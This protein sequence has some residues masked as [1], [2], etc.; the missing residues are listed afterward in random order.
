MYLTDEEICMLEQL[1][2]LDEDVAAAAGI[3]NFFGKINENMNNY[4]V[5][6]ILERFNDAALLRLATHTE[7]ICDA[8]MSGFEWAQVISYLKNSRLAQLRL[9]GIYTT[10]GDNYYRAAVWDEESQKY[11]G[12]A[13]YCEKPE[14]QGKSLEQILA[15]VQDVIK[16]PLGLCFVDDA[17]PNSAI[18]AYKGT[19]GQDE[20]ADNVEATTEYA[21]E[22]QQS[23]LAF[24]NQMASA[25]YS[26]L[27]ITGHSKGANKAMYVS[28]MCD[29]VSR[30]VCFDGQ[31]FSLNFLSAC[32]EKQQDENGNL[33]A[34]SEVTAERIANRAHIISNYSLNADFVH[35]LLHQLPGSNQI[36]V[37]GYGVNAMFENHAPNSFFIQNGIE[38]SGQPLYEN[39][40]FLQRL[41][42]DVELNDDILKEFICALQ[43]LADKLGIPF[44]AESNIWDILIMGLCF[45]EA[46][47]DPVI[48]DR[49]NSDS[50]ILSHFTSTLSLDDN[51]YPMFYGTAEA[52]TATT[53]HHLVEYL[54]S[55]GQ[56]GQDIF[57]FVSE[58][59]PQ[60]VPDQTD[61]GQY[62]EKNIKKILLEQKDMLAKTLGHVILFIKENHLDGDFVE[63]LL[64]DWS[65]AIFGHTVDAG[66]IG[67]F[68]GSAINTIGDIVINHLDDINKI[69]DNIE[70]DLK[71]RLTVNAILFREP[72][73]PALVP[74][75]EIV[76]NVE[77][78]FLE[79]I[80]EV[81][82]IC[83]TAASYYIA[84]KELGYDKYA[85]S[86]SETE[87]MIS[88]KAEAE[89]MLSG[90]KMIMIPSM[91][92][93]VMIRFSVVPAMILST[94]EHTTILSVVAMATIL[95]MV[96]VAMT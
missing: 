55:L 76:F 54:L 7:S 67:T 65:I 1:T 73:W 61:E 6:R 46:E 74:V 31:G 48:S 24:A 3:S 34:H 85:T 79:L 18:I 36:Y 94:E 27:T 63:R 95:F 78:F 62:F 56:K 13:D 92:A 26:N 72:L 14:N 8:A 17:D 71:T 9:H 77:S 4:T 11:I 93:L 69:L 39:H 22:P 84:Y 49:I 80:S 42:D 60:L 66:I 87:E 41:Y 16:C 33:V 21:T 29:N 30:C 25:G 86:D 64:A 75:A 20:W 52:E 28:I 19:T 15:Q 57:N 43:K 50:R 91:V 81:A 53:L 12:I 44:V 5:G 88:S 58:L 96:T 32:G 70:S 90:V 89:M 37:Q 10:P 40:A 51:G 47:L 23:A 38:N 35:I 2:Y 83:N 59:L 82:D 45:F 68:L